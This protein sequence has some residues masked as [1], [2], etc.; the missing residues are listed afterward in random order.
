MNDGGAGTGLVH[1]LVDLRKC[2]VRSLWAIAIGF[3][4]S[5]YFA[6]VLFDFI[7]AP[8]VPYLG[9]SGL[10]FTAPMDKFVAYLKV[11]FL[12]GTI[13]SAP[14]WLGQLWWFIAP[15]LY[16][17]EKRWAAVFIVAGTV[18]FLT[19]AFFVYH[20]VFP[21]AFK[22]LMTFGGEV[23]KPMITISEYLSFFVMM[24]LV[25]GLSFEMPLVLVLLGIL[26]VIDH[27]FLREKRRIAIVVLA[28]VSA[29]AT[30]PDAISMLALLIPLVLLYELSIWIV[31][32]LEAKKAKA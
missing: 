25:F 13:L 18:L 14:Y 30:P 27:V 4:L 17:E 23:D 12:A 9:T 20:I 3:G 32:F 5:V 19:G 16:K 22:Y 31:Y 28:V 1:H 15:G 7:R 29:V 2:V 11:S 26:G 8:I 6:D 10:V 21:M 24:T